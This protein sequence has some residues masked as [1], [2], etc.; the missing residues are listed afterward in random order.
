MYKKYITLY[1]QVCYLTAPYEVRLQRH[2]AQVAL[3]QN[4]DR[5]QDRFANEEKFMKMEYILKKL[6]IEGG[7][8][9]NEFDTS[10]HNP[11]D[12]AKRLFEDYK[13]KNLIGNK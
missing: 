8:I 13:I 5:A 1:D 12:I 7:Y 11:E 9:I 6:L 10:I 3:G 4:R 2:N